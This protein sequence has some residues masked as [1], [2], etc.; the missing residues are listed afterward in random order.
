MYFV[1]RENAPNRWIQCTFHRFDIKYSRNFHPKSTPSRHQFYFQKKKTSSSI[2]R[3]R[4]ERI[5]NGWHHF[6]PAFPWILAGG[7]AGVRDEFL[8]FFS[9]PLNTTGL[10]PLFTRQIINHDLKIFLHCRNEKPNLA[11]PINVP[12]GR[13][14]NFSFRFVSK[15]IQSKNDFE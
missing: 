14:W 15:K 9:F 8:S 7:A 5:Q 3:I 2:N 1:Q 13:G 11:K 10:V 6:K 4:T 12:D